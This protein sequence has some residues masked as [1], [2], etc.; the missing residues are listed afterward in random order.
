MNYK[1]SSVGWRTR[2]TSAN[3]NK[4]V[5]FNT[6]KISLQRIL[7][8]EKAGPR[9]IQ[10]ILVFNMRLFTRVDQSFFA[11]FFIFITNILRIIY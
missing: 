4:R 3:M 10:P 2:N 8:L 7:S 5:L 9:G 6:S 1:F 11:D